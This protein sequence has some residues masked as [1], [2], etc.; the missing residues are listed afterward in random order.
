MEEEEKKSEGKVPGHWCGGLNGV[1]D[2]A[3][4]GQE[5]A[6]VSSGRWQDCPRG[7][8]VPEAGHSG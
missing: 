6:E 8:W 7:H 4:G 3:A 2:E 1:G 5:T